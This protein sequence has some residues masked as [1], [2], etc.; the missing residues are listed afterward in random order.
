MAPSA[1][2][3]SFMSPSLAF[4][5]RKEIRNGEQWGIGDRIVERDNPPVAGFRIW[6]T[7][8]GNISLWKVNSSWKHCPGLRSKLSMLIA[9]FSC[10]R[11]ENG[12]WGLKKFKNKV[13]PHSFFRLNFLSPWLVS[14]WLALWPRLLWALG[15][16]TG[17]VP[18]CGC[19][20]QWWPGSLEWWG[21]PEHQ[22]SYS[23]P[24]HSCTR[25]C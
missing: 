23:A 6:M 8:Q 17:A 1:N 20:G 15:P 2:F 5:K 13:V 22:L 18:W 24:S 7:H 9:E 16:H 3:F 14:Q 12:I 11:S 10:Y 19:C 25:Q 4:P 21:H